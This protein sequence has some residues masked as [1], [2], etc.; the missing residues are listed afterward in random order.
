[1]VAFLKM[2]SQM[3]IPLPDAGHE[4]KGAERRMF[5]RRETSATVRGKR[6]DHS[7][8]ALRQPGLSLALRDVSLGGLSA[9]SPTRLERGERLTV[10]LPS[11]GPSLAGATR[12][13]WDATGRV[14]RCETSGLGYRIAV[15]F[16]SVPV[17]A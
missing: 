10:T 15:E 12:A 4:P 6:T 9:I 1:M 2:P 17:A 13:G 14:L 11:Q 3:T 5:P 8:A 7:L 16:D